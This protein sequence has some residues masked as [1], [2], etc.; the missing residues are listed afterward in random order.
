M[1][2]CAPWD[3]QLNDS[4]F[5]IAHFHYVLVGA[6]VFMIFAAIYYWFPKATGRLL[7]ERLG[8]WH[9]WLF[10]I[11]FHMTFDTMHFVGFLGMPRRIYTYR[12]RPRLGNPESHLHNWRRVSNR[13]G[14]DHVNQRLAFATQREAGG[15]RSLG[16]L[17][18]RVE[19]QLP[20][21][22]IQFR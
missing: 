16:R 8:K 1:L 11:G 17:D 15:Q 12:S 4:Y 22:G 19:H 5:L 6:I 2:A 7:S 9:F 10:L 20:A 18:P 21:P 3:W 13:R 14:A